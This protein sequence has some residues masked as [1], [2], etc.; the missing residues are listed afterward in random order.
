MHICASKITEMSI[1]KIIAISGKPGLFELVTQTRTGFVAKSLETEKKLA[2][3]LRHDVSILSE[4]AIYTYSD[5][6]PLPDIFEKIY[7]KEEGGKAISHK[8]SKNE[9]IAYFQE[10]LPEYDEER[11]YQRDIKKILQWYNLLLDND[12]TSF[13]SD[14]DEPEEESAEGN[15]E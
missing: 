14:V 2:V 15:E 6:I 7:D 3:N 8:S 13:T 10:I 5:E 4:I 9:L 12:I 11:V 1:E